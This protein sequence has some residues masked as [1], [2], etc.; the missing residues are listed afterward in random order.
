MAFEP[1]SDGA[2]T[3]DRSG[4]SGAPSAPSAPKHAPRRR[5]TQIGIIAFAL[6]ALFAAA[7]IAAIALAG[8]GDWGVGSLI[9]QSTTVLTIVSFVLGV[10]AVILDRGR[11]WG[12]AGIILSV[13][14]NPFVLTNLLSFFA[15][16]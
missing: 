2:R 10:V 11:G 14:A 6:A 9:G 13:V 1:S 5:G 16:F 4:S 7:D 12:V 15:Q 3:L 8:T